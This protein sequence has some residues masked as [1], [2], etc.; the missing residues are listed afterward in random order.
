MTENS[1]L[2][3]R[4]SRSSQI[5]PISAESK[6]ECQLIWWRM[7]STLGAHVGLQSFYFSGVSAP[8]PSISSLYRINRTRFFP[9]ALS[10]F[11]AKCL[12]RKKK[13][14]KTRDTA[15][16]KAALW[17][18]RGI[19]NP[20]VWYEQLQRVDRQVTS[21][22]TI[23]WHEHQINGPEKHSFYQYTFLE[24]NCLGEN[25]GSRYL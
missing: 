2:F 5:Q 12:E 22:F 13:I 11:L 23:Q 15:E 9:T 3:R 20:Q 16:L 19:E 25:D 6:C 18:K 8:S 4:V 17:L 10:I 7:L 14:T 21:T 24:W 1:R